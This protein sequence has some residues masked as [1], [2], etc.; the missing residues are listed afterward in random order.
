[1]LEEAREEVVGE[2]IMIPDDE[3]CAASVPGDDVIDDRIIDHLKSLGQ[4]WRRSGVVE[5]FHWL[6]RRSCHRRWRP[7]IL[8]TVSEFEALFL[9]SEERIH[10]YS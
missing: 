10:L 2:G 7:G 6:R 3:T 1:M 8:I 9:Y 5:A 4:E